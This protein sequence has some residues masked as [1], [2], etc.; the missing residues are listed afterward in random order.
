M[1]RGLSPHTQPSHPIPG[2][3]CLCSEAEREGKGSEHW[4]C[5]V[6]P[7]TPGRQRLRK[8]W[9]KGPQCLLL[10][11]ESSS[12]LKPWELQDQGP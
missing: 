7:H 11:Q 4:A 8:E 3:N 5:L 2:L 12:R 6:G 10:S 1:V 9:L